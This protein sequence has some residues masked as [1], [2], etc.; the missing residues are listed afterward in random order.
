MAN[1]DEARRRVRAMESYAKRSI[2]EDHAAHKDVA[3]GSS[4]RPA[5]R[6]KSSFANTPNTTERPTWAPER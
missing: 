3:A 6:P 5:Q 2:E 1:A 4:D